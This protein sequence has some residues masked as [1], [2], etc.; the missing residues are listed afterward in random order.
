MLLT[1]KTMLLI[2]AEFTPAALLGLAAVWLAM[3]RPVSS[4]NRRVFRWRRLFGR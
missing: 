2:A 1:L 3:L 4:P